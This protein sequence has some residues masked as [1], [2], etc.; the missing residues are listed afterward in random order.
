MLAAPPRYE[1]DLAEAILHRPRRTCCTRDWQWLWVS[2]PSKRP[3]SPLPPEEQRVILP[4]R[5]QR[6][7]Y[8]AA[9]RPD[10]RLAC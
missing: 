10:I 3:V 5:R 7:A 8:G 9:I 1:P 6:H 2:A 4:S